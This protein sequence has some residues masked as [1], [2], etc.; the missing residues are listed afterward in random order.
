M[1]D[2][3]REPT[4]LETVVALLALV[5]EL[6][7]VVVAFV[8]GHAVRGGA[9]GWVL[10]VVLAV[11]IVGVWSTFMSPNAARR[12]PVPGRVG[13]AVAL[14]ALVGGLWALDRPVAGLTFAVVGAA[15]MAV[16]QPMV[17]RHQGN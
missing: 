2:A 15:V 14:F 3:G 1:T 13:V 9:L 8:A 11:V 7:L 17:A 12:L 16:A 6:A 10:G 5:A 4:A